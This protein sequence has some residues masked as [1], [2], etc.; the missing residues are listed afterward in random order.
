MSRAREGFWKPKLNN[1]SNE[2]AP[3]FY[4]QNQKNCSECQK[5]I[6]I[7]LQHYNN[8]S[9]EF[10]IWYKETFNQDVWDTICLDRCKM[11]GKINY[12]KKIM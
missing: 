3:T 6:F 8:L 5:L 11:H 1:I 12:N 4:S 10:K 9:E 7:T 2:K